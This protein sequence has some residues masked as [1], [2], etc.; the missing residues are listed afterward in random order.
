MSGGSCLFVIVA[1]N[2]KPIYEAEFPEARANQRE[3]TAHLNRLT[4]VHAALDMVDELCWG[5]Q[6]MNLKQVDRFNDYLV[7]A[8]VTAGHVRFMLLHDTKNEDGIKNFFNDVHEV[9]IRLLLNPF[10]QLGVS[11]VSE[12]IDKRIRLIGKR[13]FG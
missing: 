2:D 3:D 5:T 4:V 11:P 1:P 12:T 7:S 6:S 13:Y 8:F 9:Y 10:F